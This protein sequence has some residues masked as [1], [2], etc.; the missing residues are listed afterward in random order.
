M[1]PAPTQRIAPIHLLLA[2]IATAAFITAI[3][4][5]LSGQGIASICAIAITLTTTNFVA[6]DV[7]NRGTREH[8]EAQN[9]KIQQLHNEMTGLRGD[10]RELAALLDKLIGGAVDATNQ[11]RRNA[12]GISETQRLQQQAAQLLTDIAHHLDNDPTGPQPIH[13]PIRRVQ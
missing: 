6:T 2:A 4:L 1:H 8:I 3:L 5:I 12:I 11:A 7:R 13:P 10:V 9:Q